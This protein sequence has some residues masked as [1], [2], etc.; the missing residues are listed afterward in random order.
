MSE[1]SANS[2][3]PQR[4]SL[5]ILATAKAILGTAIH[6]S[7]ERVNQPLQRLERTQ[8][9][10]LGLIPGE[11]EDP[12]EGFLVTVEPDKAAKLLGGFYALSYFCGDQ[13]NHIYMKLY[14]VGDVPIGRNLASA[15]V[16]IR[17][18]PGSN[19]LFLW[20]DAVCL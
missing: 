19:P 12:L 20:V 16:G 10:I 17:P 13:A 9:R 5:A 14:S 3:V 15:L 4:Q 11:R 18:L 1:T 6:D 2:L 8:I 7:E